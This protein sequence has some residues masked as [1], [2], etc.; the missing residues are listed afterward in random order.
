M[1]YARDGT[2]AMKLR[3]NSVLLNKFE[4]KMRKD[5]RRIEAENQK[6]FLKLMKVRTRIPHECLDSN[7]YAYKMKDPMMMGTA[8]IR[9]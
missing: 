2:G 5:Q 6:M 4:G 3:P 9:K 1:T 8:K 7:R